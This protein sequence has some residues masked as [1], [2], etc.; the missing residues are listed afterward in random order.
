[1][2]TKKCKVSTV[3]S[4]VRFDKGGNDG[5]GKESLDRRLSATAAVAGGAAAARGCGGGVSDGG[6]GGATA[7]PAT[8]ALLLP[9]N[10][11]RD[12]RKGEQNDYASILYLCTIIGPNRP[13]RLLLSR[14][15][16]LL[17]SRNSS[18]SSSSGS[19]VSGAMAITH[20]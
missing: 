9:F 20:S 2:N 15:S 18:S 8:T 4:V 13:G 7:A 17:T 10:A 5:E 12:E 14:G 16:E 6:G 1:M 19:N 3:V 11:T